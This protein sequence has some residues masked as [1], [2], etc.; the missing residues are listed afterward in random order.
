MIR[1]W[2]AT[3][4]QVEELYA[5]DE[6]ALD[7]LAPVYGLIFLFKWD[8]QLETKR[9][10]SSSPLAE[11]GTNVYFARQTVQNACATQALLSIL[12]NLQLGEGP[13]VQLGPELR[14]LGEFSRE[15]DP[16]MRGEA[17]GACE[18]IRKVHNSFSRP[19][20]GMLQ[21]GEEGEREGADDREDPFHFVSFLP[22]GGALYE[23]DG[24]KAGPICHGALGS[25]GHQWTHLALKVIQERIA[26]FHALGQAAE[27]RFNLM[28]LIKDRT[29]VYREAIEA[30]HLKMAQLASSSPQLVSSLQ[31][32]TL[33]LELR[34]QEEHAKMARYQRENAL[35]RH[36]LLPLALAMLQQMG[37]H[38]M[39]DEFV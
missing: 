5:L 20:L 15:L 2:G 12:L 22:I 8:N 32:Q 11:M 27:I 37:R 30:A 33:D 9:I 16:E 4:F 10:K 31:A 39:L 35:R 13:G 26:S 23:F 38:G 19:E 29:L 18:A 34:V 1:E 6:A 17:I 3:G 14:N 36:N 25:D 24:L 28:A 21:A 7:E